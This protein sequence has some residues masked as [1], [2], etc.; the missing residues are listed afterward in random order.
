MKGITFAPSDPNQVWAGSSNSSATLGIWKSTDGGT[1]WLNKKPGVAGYSIAVHP[2]DP[3]HVVATTGTWFLD[4]A[5]IQATTDGGTTWTT[6]YQES[7]GWVTDSAISPVNPQLAWASSLYENVLRSTNG[8]ASWQNNVGGF[9]FPGR[10]FT[11]E[12]DPSMLPVVYVPC[13][14]DAGFYFT[15]NAGTTWTEY[16]NGLWLKALVP[17]HVGVYAPNFAR[18][19]YTG[20]MGNGAFAMTYR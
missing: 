16:S 19:F 15:R 7:I 14:D 11:I 2:T 1:S 12:A 13:D 4:P 17:L 8:G 3:D 6:V 20:T 5:T 10:P 18:I 9:T